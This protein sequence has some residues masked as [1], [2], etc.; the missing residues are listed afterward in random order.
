MHKVIECTA[1]IAGW[2]EN[3]KSQK[4]Y[5]RD[6][7]NRPMVGNRLVDKEDTDP[8]VEMKLLS[9]EQFHVGTK[10][11]GPIVNHGLK[12]RNSIE[13]NISSVN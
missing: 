2:V 10:I 8:V 11:T 7:A 12:F 1:L 4:R 6:V 13:G 5:I 3:G 9:I